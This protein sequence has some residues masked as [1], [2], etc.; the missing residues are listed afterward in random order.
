MGDGCAVA[1]MLIAE[2]PR[3]ERCQ[4]VPLAFVVLRKRMLHPQLVLAVSDFRLRLQEGRVRNS[5]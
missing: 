5:S 3:G 4:N 2:E 1:A